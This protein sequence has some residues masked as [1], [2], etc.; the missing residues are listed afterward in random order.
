MEDF[1]S[2]EAARLIEITAGG[3]FI[4]QH[5]PEAIEYEASSQRIFAE[6]YT[7]A[8]EQ[9]HGQPIPVKRRKTGVSGGAAGFL[10]QFRVNE[11][12]PRR[13]SYSDG[14]RREVKEIRVIR[15]C[16]RCRLLKKPVR[17]PHRAGEFC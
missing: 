9:Y 13:S 16:L 14:R 8:Q 12:A 15:A 7:P 5:G 3:R 2:P 10:C 1:L 4:P 6:C 17:T 11:K